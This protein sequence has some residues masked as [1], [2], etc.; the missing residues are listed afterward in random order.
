M[1]TSRV[2]PALFL[3]FCLAAPF[4]R[5]DFDYSYSGD[6][7]I[8]QS[9]RSLTASARTMGL[10]PLAQVIPANSSVSFNGLSPAPDFPARLVTDRVR[11]ITE[12]TGTPRVSSATTSDA[13]AAGMLIAGAILLLAMRMSKSA[14]ENR[15]EN[16]PLKRRVVARRSAR[17]SCP[18]SSTGRRQRLAIE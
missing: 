16:R 12:N 2:V 6:E 15:L 11:T 10:A 17:A 3:F 8:S 13:G 18:R 1:G 9:G 5:A 14:P 4:V 7:S